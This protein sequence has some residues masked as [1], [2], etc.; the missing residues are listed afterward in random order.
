MIHLT[1][2]QYYVFIFLFLVVVFFGYMKHTEVRNQQDYLNPHLIDMMHTIQNEVHITSSILHTAMEE[3]QIPY[4][5]WKQLK[6]GFEA[7]EHSSYEIEKMGRAIYPNR[8]Q[9][10]AGTTK[11]TSHFIVSDL[12]HLEEEYLEADMDPLDEVIFP[13]ETHSILEPIYTTASEWKE[14]SNEYHVRTNSV[15][16]T[17]WVEMM[18]EMKK[19]SVVF[20]EQL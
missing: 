4:A 18:K 14:I 19:P 16:Q 17:Y 7:I 11:A 10:L 8:A 6:S 12:L 3:K 13:P 20:Q 9:G 2:K 5:Q 15:N 1:K